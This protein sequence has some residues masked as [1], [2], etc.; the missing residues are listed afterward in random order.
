MT[1]DIALIRL[2][3]FR[4]IT[5][6]RRFVWALIFAF[7]VLLFGQF[8]VQSIT[9]TGIDGLCDFYQEWSSARNV[10]TD[11][12][13][14]APVD[15][16]LREYL[17]LDV[18]PENWNRNVHP[19]TSVLLAIP[20]QFLDYD[21][22]FTAWSLFSLVCLSLSLWLIARSLEFQLN[23]ADLLPTVSLLLLA[24]PF[25]QQMIQGQLNLVLL[26]LVTGIWVADRSKQP[27]A[28]GLLIALATA[29]KIFPGFFFVYL[30]LKKDGKAIVAGTIG[31]LAITAVTAIVVGVEAYRDYIT[32]V[33]P[34]AVRWKGAYTNASIVGLW[35]KL[36]DPTGFQGPQVAL[37]GSPLLSNALTLLSAAIVLGLLAHAVHCCRRVGNYDPAF[38]LSATAMLIISPVTWEHYFL[39]TVPALAIFWTAATDRPLRRL[40]IAGCVVVFSLPTLWITNRFAKEMM[41]DSNIAPLVTLTLLSLPCYALMALFATGYSLKPEPTI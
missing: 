19:P 3:P 38:A 1:R 6:A 2:D 5:P 30:A 41:V 18:E 26:L 4:P 10:F 20:F 39:L 17:D 36:F 23:S 35:T 28:A 15:V 14:Y 16:S 24:E 22:A 8:F 33:M 21:R 37:Y 40:C 7:T 11:L 13:V 12:P 27:V 9:R 29:I 31:F 25:R 34:D 32:E